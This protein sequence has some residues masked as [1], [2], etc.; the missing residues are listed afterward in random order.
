M[1]LSEQTGQS[2]AA[3]IPRPATLRES[4]IEAIQ[5]LIVSGQLKPGQHLVES[6]LAGLLGVSRQPVREALQQLSGEGWVDLHPGQGAFVHV[7]TVQE[8]DQLLAVRA[9][10]ETESARLA[11]KHAG[12]DGVKR[13]REL[14]EQGIAAVESDD[15]DTAVALNSDLHGLVT[16]LSGNAVLA[17]LAAQVARRVRWYHTPVARRRGM[18]SW[19]EHTQLI[20]AIE[21]GDERRAAKIMRE[22]TEHTR[23]SYMAQRE[24]E[25]VEPAP[26]PVRRRRPRTPYA[27]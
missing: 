14:C 2:A 20:D 25:P 11:A 22:H 10:L 19:D 13:L 3:K 4:V 17:E 16:A 7:P 27:G 18:A 23:I 15:V 9:L 24:N 21:A 6:E 26:K 1:L 8:A 5:E 12:E